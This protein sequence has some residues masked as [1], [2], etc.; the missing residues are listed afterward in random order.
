MVK[1]T[2]ELKKTIREYFDAPRSPDPHSRYRLLL[3][4]IEL[5]CQSEGISVKD[6]MDEVANEAYQKIEPR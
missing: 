6:A 3:T 1:M 4:G 5:M 2:E